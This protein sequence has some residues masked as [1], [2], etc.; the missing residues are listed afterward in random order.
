MMCFQVKCEKQH[1]EKKVKQHKNIIHITDFHSTFFFCAKRRQE[2]E[3]IIFISLALRVFKCIFILLYKVEVLGLKFFFS[4][5]FS[6]ESAL[7]K[8]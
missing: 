7:S 6:E 8:D 3:E 5:Q 1:R 2:Q 4:T